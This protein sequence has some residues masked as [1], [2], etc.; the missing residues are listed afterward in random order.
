MSKFIFRLPK[1]H[2]FTKRQK[3][4]TTSAI[5]TL[6]LL[7][8]QLVPY[9]LTYRFIIG[10]GVIAYV[11]SLWALWEGMTRVK[12]IVLLLLPIL[13]TVAV[14]A[15]YFLLPV[16]WLTR[17]PV[18]V[19]FG[20]SYYCLLLSQNVFN[21]SAIRTIPLYRAASTVTFLFSLITAF[22][23]FNVILSFGMLFIW[24]G[25]GVF[26]ISLP[27]ILQMLWS[28]EMEGVD[29]V[30]VFTSLFLSL[31]L[32]EVAL[33]LSFWPISGPMAS[34]ILAT[35]MYVIL[36]ISTHQFRGRLTREVVLEYIGVGGVVFLVA[37]FTTSWTR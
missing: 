20:V 37:L 29:N 8:T 28:I 18:A 16:R 14:A 11:L 3:I 10:L 24:N 19:A 25:I 7:Y 31:V 36:G 32:G 6:G 5:L 17:L 30:L 23:L 12:A 27:L 34:L 26:L 13:F 4:V 21:V 15:Y 35:A 33:S 9:Y 22:L 2:L 1:F